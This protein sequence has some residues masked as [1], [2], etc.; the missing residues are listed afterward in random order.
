MG[1]RQS[2]V[3]EMEIHNGVLQKYNGSGGT[4]SFQRVW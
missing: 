3:V 2:K 4:L 1:L